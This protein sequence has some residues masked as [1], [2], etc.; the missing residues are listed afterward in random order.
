MGWRHLTPARRGCS[1]G[2]A[3]CWGCVAEVVALQAVEDDEAAAGVAPD[4]DHAGIC[5]VHQPGAGPV[6]NGEHD[7]PACPTFAFGPTFS[8]LVGI[9][10]ESPQRIVWYDRHHPDR[11]AHRFIAEI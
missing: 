3:A 7:Q 1:P 5:D 9:L 8:V 2:K 4:V 11:E 6:R 10:E